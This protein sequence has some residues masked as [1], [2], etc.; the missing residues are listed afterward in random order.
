MKITQG[1]GATG[2]GPADPLRYG[3]HRFGGPS[4]LPTRADPTGSQV[5]RDGCSIGAVTNSVTVVAGK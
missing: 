2:R 1:S 5:L 4:R 3:R